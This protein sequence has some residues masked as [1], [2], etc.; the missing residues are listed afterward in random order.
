[1]KALLLVMFI[2]AVS[3]TASAQKIEF[4][5]LEYSTAVRAENA[6]V[7]VRIHPKMNSSY[8]LLVESVNLS[9]TIDP[10]TKKLKSPGK[11]VD[12]D[13]TITEAQ[14][15]AIVNALQQIK[16]TDVS[17]GPHPSLLDGSS[18]YISYGARGTSVTFHANTPDYETDKRN[19]TGFLNAYKLILKT[20]ELDPKAIL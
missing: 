9:E 4:V 5:T 17:G 20:A 1:M 7:K 2:L 18:C 8:R 15:I 13:T 12:K 16:Q 6:H 3:F 19:L 11:N 10:V 14:F